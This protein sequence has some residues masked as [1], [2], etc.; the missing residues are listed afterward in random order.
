MTPEQ[1]K[2]LT[3]KLD[4]DPATL[5]SNRLIELCVLARTLPQAGAAYAAKLA[6]HLKTRF[7][8]ATIDYEIGR[9]SCRERV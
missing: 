9:A 6:E 5:D 8:A 1:L 3:A 4:A 7:P 2:T